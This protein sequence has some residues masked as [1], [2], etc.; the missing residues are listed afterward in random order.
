ME[1][2]PGH[3]VFVTSI[4]TRGVF[5]K[6][7]LSANFADD[8]R[9]LLALALDGQPL[10]I[11]HGYPCRIIAPNRPGVRQTKWVQ[12]LEVLGMVRLLLAGVG[13]VAV[14]Y[15]AFLLIDDPLEDLVSVATWLVG[16]VVLHDLVISAPGP[17]A[18]RRRRSVGCRTSIR[19]PA[20]VGFVVLGSVTLLAVPV[21]GRFGATPDNP[22]LLDRNYGAGWLLVAG[23]TLL[24][25]QSVWRPR[26]AAGARRG[27][28]VARVLVVDDDHT[29]REVVVSLPARAPASRSTRRR[30]ARMRC[31]GCA[32]R[33]RTWSSST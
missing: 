8:D 21:L 10:A 14:A 20:A 33:R 24:R 13:L 17:A 19:A 29:V 4:E 15:G 11:D 3:D 6:S 32:R 2:P 25:R 23:L 22:T 5:D 26:S 12:R 18:G 9:T 28:T 30:T 27:G 1:A 16:G 7:T 31:A